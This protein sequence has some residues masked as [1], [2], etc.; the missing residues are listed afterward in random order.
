L[1]TNG[2]TTAKVVQELT[3]DNT[4]AV[5]DNLAH[6]LSAPHLGP[7]PQAERSASTRAK[8]IAATIKCLHR[9]GYSATT[10]SLVAD[11]AKV[12]RG[13][14]T[15]QFPTKLDL[16]LAVVRRIADDELVQYKRQYKAA[17]NPREAFFLLPHSMWKIL[18]RPSGMAVTEI[19]MASRSDP[20]LAKALAPI[21]ME[22]ERSSREYVAQMLSA[23][24]IEPR[25]DGLA[26][27]RVFQAVIRG[28]AIN[29]LFTHD[30][31]EITA[32][33]N[34]LETILRLLYGDTPL[35]GGSK[36]T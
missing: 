30:Q 12:S 14:M 10:V 13:A 7:R 33:L 16:M 19:M 35:D 20:A 36:S 5:E 2:N 27:N 29:A 22:G 3:P 1:I 24:K 34:A 15:H 6:R 23:A 17:K 4:A 8:L 18:S 32:P 28:L 9:F 31:Q 21:Q 26:L 25:R 11:V